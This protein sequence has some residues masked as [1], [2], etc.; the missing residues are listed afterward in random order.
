ML[1]DPGA[2][3]PAAATAIHGISDAHVADAAKTAEALAALSRFVGDRPIVG[4]AVGYDMAVLAAEARRLRQEPLAPPNLCTRL[5]AEMAAPALP[6]FTL[7]TLGAWL[8]VAA[9]G[10]PQRPRA[11]R[12]RRRKSSWRCCRICATAASAPGR[13]PSGRCASLPRE[14]AT[15]AAA[16]EAAAPAARR[17]G[18]AGRPHRLLAYR[19]RVGDVMTSPPRFLEGDSRFARRC[20]SWPRSGSAPSLSAARQGRAS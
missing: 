6:D 17:R 14:P 20:A 18:R 10:A 2:P 1:V 16:V 12:A 15:L 7:E 13:R 5:L 4:H 3:I 9:G 19:H 11:T 8:G